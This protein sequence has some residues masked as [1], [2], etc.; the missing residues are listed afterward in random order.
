MVEIDR[1]TDSSLHH[2]LLPALM[3]IL[4]VFA[5]VMFWSIL[6]SIG[7]S[8]RLLPTGLLGWLRLPAGIAPFEKLNLAMADVVAY[9]ALFVAILIAS[10][11]Q[12]NSTISSA[13]SIADKRPA[14]AA[15]AKQQQRELKVY[16]GQAEI[17]MLMSFGSAFGVLMLACLF[18][19]QEMALAAAADEAVDQHGVGSG[20][21]FASIHALAHPRVSFLFFVSLLL[22]MTTY[23]SMPSWK[24]T[25]IF[26]RQVEDNAWA[27][28][29]RLQLISRKH[30]LA[31]VRQ[32]THPFGAAAATTVGY[33]V[34]VA[35]VTLLLNGAL[36]LFAS[37]DGFR[38]LLSAEYAEF[39]VALS[40]V[41]V[42]V[43]TTVASAMLRVMH[44]QGRNNALVAGSLIVVLASALYVVYAEGVTWTIAL[45]AVIVLHGAL[46]AFLYRRAARVLDEKNPATWEFLLNPP[47]Y[48]VMRR[49]EKIRA[50]A[51][52]LNPNTTD[53]AG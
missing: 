44:L 17:S 5:V 42:T 30:N 39:L 33:V 19:L 1:H 41:A 37:G 40:L 31:N 27:A 34:Y 11:V 20:G 28:R 45:A 3:R 15:E 18:G 50:A 43:S 22:F 13:D 29:E 26:R 25:D 14:T 53:Q 52:S 21:F 10:T 32:I 7:Y 35:L 9:V 23:A 16:S 38:N 24:S 12:L 51:A 49:Y 4:V 2:S 36:V 8:Y 6:L 48:V 47:K 46:W